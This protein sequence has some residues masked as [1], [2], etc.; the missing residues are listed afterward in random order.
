MV[1]ISSITS[2][3]T[4][5][6]DRLFTLQE[7]TTGRQATQHGLSVN[8][9]GRNQIQSLTVMRKKQTAEYGYMQQNPFTAKSL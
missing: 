2:G 9:T 4:L 6:L 1:V 3:N 8:A 7:I 5:R